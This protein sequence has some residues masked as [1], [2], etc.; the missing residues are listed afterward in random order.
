MDSSKLKM[1]EL[2]ESQFPRTS[3]AIQEALKEGV[4][5][6]FVAGIWQKSEPDVIRVAA[7][8]NRRIIPTELPMAP[9]TV[10]DLASVSKVFATGALAAVLVDRGWLTWDAPVR[11]FFPEYEHAN[12]QVRHLLAHTSGLPA[13]DPIWEK[14]QKGFKVF[15]EKPIY[16]I[17]I[18][19]RQG[20]ARDIVFAIEPEVAVETRALYSDLSFIILGFILEK[21]TQMPL[22]RAVSKFVWEPMGILGA[23]YRR[24]NR[25]LLDSIDD[26]V[27]ATEQ[28]FWRGGI[29]QGQVHD[30]NCLAMGGYAGHAGAFGTV[31]D[32]LHFSKKLMERFLTPSTLKAIWTRVGNPHGCDRTLGWDTPSGENPSSSRRF[33][34]Y[35]VGHLG[36]TGTSLWIDPDVGLAVSL[37][38]N[39]VHPSRENIKIRAFRPRFHEAIRLDLNF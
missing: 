38:S 16:S 30:D 29:L 37:L 24:V 17:D 32:V 4:A 7:A 2:S 21:I 34:T 12:I 25:S 14:L 35:S 19:K 9:D 20:M 28:C 26:S 15:L 18:E 5:P 3:R 1:L 36:Y 11:A 6:G 33:S 31:R 22:D 13:W 27:A 10:F 39:R 8:G 23:Y